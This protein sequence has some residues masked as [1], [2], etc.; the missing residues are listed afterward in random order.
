MARGR[1][2]L[3]AAPRT[4]KKH[5]NYNRGTTMALKPCRECGKEVSDAANTC[6]NCG[7]KTPVVAPK[8]KSIG[9]LGMSAIAV[10]LL[11]FGNFIHWALYPEMPETK[12]S[13]ASSQQQDDALHY[14]IPH[15]P[16]H[17][18]EDASIW[19]RACLDSVIRSGLANGGKFDWGDLSEYGF[20]RTSSAL[21]MACFPEYNDWLNMCD[22]KF[23]I[24][25]CTQMS[26]AIPQEEWYAIVNGSR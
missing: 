5:T 16:P 25:R 13:A 15:S 21:L 8:S 22:S 1:L 7:I 12:Q 6:P 17:T 14:S 18:I 10:A 20:P 26:A 9:C 23:G 2:L 19:F 4:R 24:D 3:T 11:L